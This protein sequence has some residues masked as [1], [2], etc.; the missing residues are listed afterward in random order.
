MI[1]W[2]CDT[3]IL[4]RRSQPQCILT[5]SAKRGNNAAGVWLC[6]LPTCIVTICFVELFVRSNCAHARSRG[7]VVS[8]DEFEHCSDFS[9][10]CTK[11]MGRQSLIVHPLR[12]CSFSNRQT[13]AR[14][15]SPHLRLLTHL[16]R[17]VAAQN[18]NDWIGRVA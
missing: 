4:Q 8:T 17:P 16:V 1:R 13:G 15:D 7:R 9:F 14:A 2:S 3:T 10:G 5:T 6:L 11:P 12:D 18:S